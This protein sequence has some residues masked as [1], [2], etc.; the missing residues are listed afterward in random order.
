MLGAEQN[1]DLNELGSLMVCL[2]TKPKGKAVAISTV[3]LNLSN[4]GSF[5]RK[6]FKENNPLE[7]Q[8]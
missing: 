8:Y 6:I 7:Y 2:P 5:Q 1:L 4:L 3:L